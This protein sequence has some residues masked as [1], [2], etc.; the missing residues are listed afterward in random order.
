[1]SFS[2]SLETQ[3][4]AALALY[5]LSGAPVNH[6]P[7]IRA[8]IITSLANLSGANDLE[9]K[10]YS[11]M[12]LANL[13][14]N[15]ETR[16]AATRSGGLQT[17]VAL[18]KDE[19]LDCR[20]YACIAM[21]NMANSPVTQEQ[22]VVHGALP[23]IL[24]MAEDLNDLESQRQALLA[25]N[26]LS[27][28]EVNHSTMVHK[29]TIKVLMKAFAS[30]DSATVVSMRPQLANMCSNP[31]YLELLGEEGAVPCLIM[32]SRSENLNTVLLG[33]TAFA[34]LPTWKPTG[35]A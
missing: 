6:V 29:G 19:D 32:L 30:K 15:V 25:L 1:M 22:L 2:K 10:R 20:R 35:R 8:D 24:Q 34:V 27:A 33:T 13:A 5:N 7:M 9:C 12:T 11:I 3:R 4:S 28:C 23:M 17:A 18:G 26:N 31:D 21:T 16:A 14:A